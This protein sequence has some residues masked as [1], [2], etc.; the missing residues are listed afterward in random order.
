ML[1]SIGSDAAWLTDCQVSPW[2]SYGTCSAKCG[3]GHKIYTREVLR[4]QTPGGVACPQRMNASVVCNTNSC[5]V[6]CQL[7]EWGEWSECSR[8]CNGGQRKRNRGVL[9]AA[10]GGGRSCDTTFDLQ[11]CGGERCDDGCTYASW[12][13]WSPCSKACDA[14]ERTR[15][16][17]LNATAS[18]GGWGCAERKKEKKSCDKQGCPDA[19]GFACGAYSDIVLLLDGSELMRP[20]DYEDQKLFTTELLKRFGVANLGGVWN[21][22]GTPVH[23]W[24]RGPH[25]YGD[26]LGNQGEG[27][28]NSV[29]WSAYGG[30]TT[31]QVTWEWVT[32]PWVGSPMYEVVRQP[33]QTWLGWTRTS[34]NAT[35][36]GPMVGAV[37]YGAD[38]VTGAKALTGLS[39][40]MDVVRA[41]IA[42][43]PQGKGG[44]KIPAAL[45][46]AER[47][48][49]RGRS[50]AS[51][52]VVLL[53]QGDPD[54]PHLVKERSRRLQDMG[55]RVVIIAVGNVRNA[56]D[57]RAAAS[58]PWSQNF[59]QVGSFQALTEQVA[60]RVVNLCPY[61][62]ETIPGG[63]AKLA[64]QMAH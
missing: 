33:V 29:Y 54:S 31:T 23:L 22:A 8:T 59:F 16:R 2:V 24:Q 4:T 44:L 7:A 9:Q 6:D 20:V 42:A 49:V 28:I 43:E 61:Q 62:P 3:G 1:K 10:L 15:Y 45:A 12:S 18:I 63:W 57:L 35:P 46:E 21:A 34:V 19:A 11:P 5:P 17:L 32:G 64:S 41:A 26:Y 48:L 53:I 27:A 47:Q 39:A 56:R 38:T 52:I 50:D 13:E 37:L 55:V 51:S 36:P 30:S 25:V 60:K 40:D 14:G 58:Y